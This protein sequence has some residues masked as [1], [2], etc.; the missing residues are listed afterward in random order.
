MAGLAAD[1]ASL[2][3]AKNHVNFPIW[4][5]KEKEHLLK[6]ISADIVVTI[7]KQKN[8]CVCVCVC[9]CVVLSSILKNSVCLK[10][11]LLQ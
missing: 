8:F 2:P 7:A 10:K 1:S 11:L 9:V 6:E 4:P 3:G 5:L